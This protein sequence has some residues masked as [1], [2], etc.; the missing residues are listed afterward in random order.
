MEKEK[1]VKEWIKLLESSQNPRVRQSAAVALGRL[2]DR[3]AV[4]PLIHL[5][6]RDQNLSVRG[7]AAR[8]LGELGDSRAVNPLIDAVLLG[9]SVEVRA[10]AAWALG[11]IGDPIAVNPLITA[12]RTIHL[13]TPQTRLALLETRTR[14]SRTRELIS[15][16]TRRPGSYDLAGVRRNAALALG[17]LGAQSA[18]EPLIYAMRNDLSMEVRRSAAL[19]L[20]EFLSELDGQIMSEM[21]TLV[22]GTAPKTSVEEETIEVIT[23]PIPK[24]T[25]FSR[26]RKVKLRCPSCQRIIRKSEDLCSKCGKGLSRCTVCHKVIDPDDDYIQCP[27]CMSLAHRDHLEEWLQIKPVCP[28]CQNQIMIQG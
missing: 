22:P 28:Y 7:A 11:R 16:S 25:S 2:G 20:G 3:S 17:R 13:V 21:E 12:L 6:K 14:Y 4:K 26:T 8:A 24:P 18:I 15:R 19:A 23:K 1:S 10:N 9:A 5:L 27:H